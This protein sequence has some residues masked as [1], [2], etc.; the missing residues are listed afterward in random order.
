MGEDIELFRHL[1]AVL[2]NN[3]F[4]TQL[5][6]AYG[7]SEFSIGY[8]RLIATLLGID[9]S[10][11]ETR[12]DWLARPLSDS[13]ISYAAM[14]VFYLGQLYPL[15]SNRLAQKGLAHWHQ[16]DCDN[17]IKTIGTDTDPSKAWRHVKQVWQLR[18]QQLAVL[19][20]LC[21]RRE[22][23]ARSRD[24]SR[25]R[26]IPFAALWNLARYQPTTVNELRRIKG[27]KPQTIRQSGGSDTS[28]DCPGPKDSSRQLSITPSWSIA[29]T[30]AA[31]G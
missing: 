4:D 15:L 28:L 5:A 22:T 27:M 16:E 26:L 25:N 20:T 8:Q 30:G 12:S 19:Q 10:K 14:D 7:Y 17:Q 9:I 18:P 1:L 3:V 29:Q 21:Q 6:A 13:Q 31:G 2:P 23:E 24:L 11:G